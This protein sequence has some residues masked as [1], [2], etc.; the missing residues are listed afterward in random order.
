MPDSGEQ[1]LKFSTFD[2]S[3][4]LFF[5]C[6]AVNY[7]QANPGRVDFYPCELLSKPYVGQ[8]A[9]QESQLCSH[10]GDTDVCYFGFVV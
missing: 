9:L 4:A 1:R 10:T 5:P 3:A 7:K 8:E 2:P 6:H